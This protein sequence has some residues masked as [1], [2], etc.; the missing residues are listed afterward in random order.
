MGPMER[1]LGE[2]VEPAGNAE[3]GSVGVA[4]GVLSYHERKA[5]DGAR[6]CVL[7]EKERWEVH[8]IPGRCCQDE[9]EREAYLVWEL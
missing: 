6:Q 9:A 7:G 5:W 8:C 1:V 2:C 3:E 4:S